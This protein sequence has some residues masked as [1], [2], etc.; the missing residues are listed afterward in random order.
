MKEQQNTDL[1]AA[2]LA[3]AVSSQEDAEERLK[4][5]TSFISGYEPDSIGP[6]LGLIINDSCKRIEAGLTFLFLM[7]RSQLSS[8]YPD[9]NWP[10][11]YDWFSKTSLETA[12]DLFDRIPSNTKKNVFAKIAM[13][14]EVIYIL[15]LDELLDPDVDLDCSGADIAVRVLKSKDP[16][17]STFSISLSSFPVNIRKFMKEILSELDFIEYAPGQW[18]FSF[19]KEMVEDYSIGNNLISHKGSSLMSQ[20]LAQRNAENLIKRLELLMKT[21]QMFPS[22]HPSIEPSTESFTSILSKFLLENAQV[23][24]SIMGDIVMVNDLRV[25]RKNL[26]TGGFVRS[27][28]DRNISSISFSPG[29]TGDQIQTFAKIFNRPPVYIAEHGG[30]ARLIELRG[31]DTISINR[32]HYELIAEQGDS[33]RTLARSEVTVED[34][35]FSE[36]ID[37]LERGDSIDTLPG[38]NI[39]DALKSVLAAANDDKEEQR[40]LIA[41]FITALDPS[42]LE[43]GLLS[44][45]Y[46]QRG[47]AWKAIRKIIDSL[48]RSLSSP[49]PD[50]RHRTVGKLQDM[51]L[52]AVERGK[53]NSSSQIIESISRALKR[54]HDPDVLYRAVILTASLMESL[55][56]RGNMSIALQAGNI[57]SN[58]QS[59]QYPRTELEA[60]RKRSLSEAQRK[61]D[62]LSAAEALVPRLLSDD[63]NI[64]KEAAQLA[65]ILPPDN[66]VSQLVNIFNE[67]NRRLR[68]KAFKI[69]LS[70]GKRGLSPIHGKLKD[71]VTAFNSQVDKATFSLPD[72]DWYTAR[73]MIQVLR[74]IGSSS[75]ETVLADLCRIPDH[76]IRRECLLALIKSSNTTAESLALHLISDESIDVSVIALNILTK[77]AAFNPAYIPK[78][79]SAFRKN[80]QIRPE[81]MD[82]FSIL[83]KNEQV[84]DFLLKCLN[85]GESG[86]LFEDSN[87]ASGAFLILK[88]YGGSK[89]LTVLEKLLSNVEGGFFKKSRINRQLL[90]KLKDVILT[91]KL[92]SDVIETEE[93]KPEKPDDDEITILGNFQS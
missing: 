37:R 38:K 11:L 77:Q 10:V 32:F 9:W 59:M 13:L 93:S 68:A 42:L 55:L 51:A 43:K 46:V 87:L 21:L 84:R 57:L 91:L 47:M 74:D 50:V 64:S 4:A 66:L 69:L 25:E 8:S 90:Q 16:S 44:N 2:R 12:W 36:L 73:N 83:G 5:L 24:L 14:I 33:D 53:E 41:R 72:S 92:S 79:T 75:S 54:E 56:T 82:S 34:A 22:G 30:M 48:L 40:G 67:D 85:E 17:S 19:S 58:L 49:D 45:I 81:I 61:L 18:Q 65:A 86:Q 80:K 3:K 29:I 70:M 7:D 23:T 26:G 39:G 27:F 35:I 52:L 28:S 76:R 20:A 1:A 31:L 88:R 6:V 63:M 60:A 89:E 15:I 71:I 62:T 78:L